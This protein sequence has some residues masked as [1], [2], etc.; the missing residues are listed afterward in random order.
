MGII[1]LQ[2][3]GIPS[4]MRRRHL[5][6]TTETILAFYIH[7]GCHTSIHR[8]PHHHPFPI[9]KYIMIHSKYDLGRVRLSSLVLHFQATRS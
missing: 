8:R 2:L 1:Y 4:H 5:S 6:T 3:L 9:N 7:L